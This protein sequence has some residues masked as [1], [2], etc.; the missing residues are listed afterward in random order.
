MRYMHCVYSDMFVRID[1]CLPS[2]LGFRTLQIPG[3]LLQEPY[4][5]PDSSAARIRFV[6]RYG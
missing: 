4:L 6:G 1:V 3:K 2:C 5:G